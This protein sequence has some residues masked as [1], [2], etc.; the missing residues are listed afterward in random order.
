MSGEHGIGITKMKFLDR[1]RVK[2]LADY[3]NGVDPQGIMN[4]GM[5]SNTDI[6]DEVFT[7]SF[8]LLEL[9]ARILQHGSLAELSNKIARCIRCGKCMP[10]CCVYH[11]GTNLFFHPR[12]KNMVIGSLIEA[13]LYDMQRSH[14]PEFR[15]LANLEEVADHCT[16]CGKCLK[17]CP[18]DIDTARVSVLEREILAGHGYKHTAPATRLSLAYL[19]SRNQTFN[20]VFRKTVMQWGSAAQ[21]G[22]VKAF[23]RSPQ[24]IRERQWRPLN[25]LKA[26]MSTPSPAPL[27]SVL[28][29]YSEDEALVLPQQGE[30]QATVFYFPGCGSE[31][32]Y[33]EVG[34]ASLYLLLMHGVRV[35]LPPQNLC[36]GFPLEV[37]AK[38]EAAEEVALRNSI[39][40]SQIREML[41]HFSFSAVVV[42]CGT[43]NEA[44]HKIGCEEIFECQLQDISAFL[45]NS[46]KWQDD[47]K[48]DQPILY[49]TPCHDS[50]KGKGVTFLRRLYNDVLPIANCCSEAGT[51][52]L[53]RP[54]IANAMRLRKREQLEKGLE[55]LAANG[56]ANGAKPFIA[57]NCPSC[58]TGLGRNRDLG[59]EPIHIAVLLANRL[60]ANGSWQEELKTI[61]AKGERVVF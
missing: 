18:V 53:S 49:H 4:P 38:K 24:K 20:N 34:M 5:L 33:A 17:P 37:N 19:K 41:G 43:C 52:A 16:M 35:V 32:L 10:D 15:Q 46:C 7:P 2:A 27:F 28:P 30:L 50:M 13:L 56:T 14:Q 11:P 26:P 61:A 45:L 8:N 60:A 25:M 40:L 58:L 31:R 6:L 3:R 48:L 1:N 59:V 22:A 23:A 47:E 21:Q 51:L 39:I 36:C 42:S 57:T 44:L 9:E 29:Q 12:N 54:D 55:L